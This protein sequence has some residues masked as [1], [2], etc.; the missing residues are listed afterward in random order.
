MKQQV[1]FAIKM[2]D[3]KLR[4]S[5]ENRWQEPDV[6]VGLWKI[7]MRYLNKFSRKW[8]NSPFNISAGMSLKEE[9]TTESFV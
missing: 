1:V 8:E 5:L 3:G 2:L 4:Q 6:Y 9:E 7:L